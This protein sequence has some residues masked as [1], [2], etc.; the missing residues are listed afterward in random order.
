MINF[1]NQGII[2]CFQ[3]KILKI[4]N[5]KNKCNQTGRSLFQFFFHRRDVKLSRKVELYSIN[6]LYNCKLIIIVKYYY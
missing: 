4:Q 6:L 2:K 3:F 5:M 1:L